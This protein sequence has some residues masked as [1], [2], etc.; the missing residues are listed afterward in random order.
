MRPTII[1]AG[2]LLTLAGLTSA[3]GTQTEPGG[4]PCRSESSPPTPQ[5]LHAYRSAS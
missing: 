1:A 5:D 2:L 4:Q 3:T